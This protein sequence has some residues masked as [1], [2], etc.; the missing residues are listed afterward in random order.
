MKQ[1]TGRLAIS[2]LALLLPLA[3]AWGQTA[4]P[5]A[6]PAPAA[7]AAEP[8]EVVCAICGVREQAGP[9]PVAA[10]YVYRGKTYYFCQPACKEEFRRE[11]E[12]WIKAAAD[13]P[14]K[15]PPAKPRAGA[16]AVPT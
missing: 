5:A 2:I 3:G 16:S 11:P 9:E 13:L 7:T 8:E 10:T 4:E 15:P 6:G 1:Q 12:K 14:P